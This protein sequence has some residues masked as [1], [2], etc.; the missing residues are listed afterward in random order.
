MVDV[1]EISPQ[2]EMPIANKLAAEIKRAW[3]DVAI[4]P[5]E[6]VTILVGIETMREIDLLVVVRLQ[7]PRLLP[8]MKRRDG[9]MAAPDYVQGAVLLIEVKQL[10]PECFTIVGTEIFPVRAGKVDR[11]SVSQQATSASIALRAFWRRYGLEQFFVYALGWL[12]EVGPEELA[13]VSP[14]IVGSGVTWSGLLDA[15]AQKNREIYE[16][17]TPA[18]LDALNGLVEILTRKRPVSP[19]DRKRALALCNDELAEQLVSELAAVAGTKMIRITGRGGSGKTT[20]LALLAKRLATIGGERVLILTFHRALRGDIAH[21]LATTTDVPGIVGRRMVVE[22]ATAF[23]MKALAQ[24]GHA[25][26]KDERE[27][28]RYDKLDWALDELRGMLVGDA[29]SGDAAELKSLRPEQFDFDYVF[30]DEAQDWT[31]AERDFLRALYGARRLVLADGLEQLVRR[32]NPCEWNAGVPSSERIT[33]HLG[34]SLRMTRNLADFANAVARAS[35]LSDWKIAPFEKLPGGRVVIS[36]G[37]EVDVVALHRAV[38]RVAEAGGASP[39]DTLTCIPARSTD[40]VAYSDCAQKLIAAGE[41]VW[42]GTVTENR[43]DAPADLECWRLVKYDSCR[44]LEGWVTIALGLDQLIASKTKYPNLQPGEDDSPENVARR[45]L[46]MAITRVVST[47]IITITD[48][49]APLV[50]TLRSAAATLPD[51]VVEWTTP[52]H[53]AEVIAPRIAAM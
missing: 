29:N 12:T 24:F 3:P 13:G 37:G 9:T 16:P 20:T 18:Y 21:V 19:L 31:N 52:E 51:G 6:H 32:Q 39:V 4:S 40:A 49:K 7:T 15:A 33:R 34:R 1:I 36:V 45:W 43:D 48:P 10:A 23:F 41:R 42:D 2:N 47:L 27:M 26:P 8:A 35:G 17:R 53:L 44:G 22:T 25:L 50:A 11:E 38:R 30:V 46:M 5:T 28:P 14:W